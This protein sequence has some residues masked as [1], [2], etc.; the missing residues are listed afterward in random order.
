MRSH[1]DRKVTRSASERPAVSELAPGSICPNNSL[2]RRPGRTNDYECVLGGNG[3]TL[4]LST[5]VTVEI[6]IIQA[7]DPG[8]GLKNDR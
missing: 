3:D 2:E 7:D 4:N 1:S 8:S 6:L 5:T